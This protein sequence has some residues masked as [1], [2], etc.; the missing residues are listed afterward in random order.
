MDYRYL[1]HSGLQVSPIRLGTMTFGGRAEYGN[2]GSTDV[3]GAR[4][5]IGIAI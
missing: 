5:P 4:R 3:A 1:G 2:T